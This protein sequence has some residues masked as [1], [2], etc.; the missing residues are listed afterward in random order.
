MRQGFSHSR[1]FEGRGYQSAAPSY[2]RAEKRDR[3]DRAIK[4]VEDQLRSAISKRNPD[5][6]FMLSAQL[7]NLTK[8][9]IAL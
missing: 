5:R 9:R 6:V 7:N 8:Q 3:L 4:R 1:P 2:I